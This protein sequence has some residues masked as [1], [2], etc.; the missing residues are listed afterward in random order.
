MHVLRLEA[1]R[2]V[3][4]RQ[5]AIDAEAVAGARR[6]F[7]DFGFA[8]AVAVALER[9][10]AVALRAFQKQRHLACVGRP[11]PEADAILDGLGAERHAVDQLGHAEIAG[12]LDGSSSRTKTT[13]ER[14]ATG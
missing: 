1:R 4:H 12:I 8:P 2:R 13:V 6:G 14:E 11:E 9:H 10:L 3:G 7:G 5:V